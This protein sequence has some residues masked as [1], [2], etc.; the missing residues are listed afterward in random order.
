MLVRVR[1]IPEN[2]RLIVNVTTVRDLFTKLGLSSEAFIVLVNGK[3]VLD[4]YVFKGDEDVI[5]V[6]VLSGG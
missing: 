1:I 2:K 3:P 6:R 4:N 5:I